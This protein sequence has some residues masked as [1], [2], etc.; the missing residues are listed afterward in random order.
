MLES[1]T[2]M[3]KTSAITRRAIP[4]EA[5]QREKSTKNDGEH[6]I[7]ASSSRRRPGQA[8]HQR[9]GGNIDVLG[10]AHVE[11]EPVMH[12]RADAAA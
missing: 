2:V 9:L 6:I 10:A 7:K 11:P 4:F 1:P 8:R 5:I 3:E 12:D